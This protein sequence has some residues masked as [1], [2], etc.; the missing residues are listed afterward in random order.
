MSDNTDNFKLQTVT[1]WNEAPDGVAIQLD[2]TE[3]AW[4]YGA[5]PPRGVYDIKLFPQKDGV[6]MGRTDKNDP[7]TTY[8]MINYEG[9]VVS[10]NADYTDVPVFGNVSTRVFRGKN[11]STAAGLLVKVGVKNLPSPI[12]DKKLAQFVEQ[13]LKKEVTVK[14]ELDWRGQYKHTNDKGEDEY[15]PVFNHYEEFPVDP[16]KGG[17]KHVVSVAKRG[18]GQ[19]EVRAQL[20]VAR[21]FA[22]G[23]TL[24]SFAPTLPGGLVSGPRT[25]SLPTTV[26]SA[27]SPVVAAPTP[28]VA[29][30]QFVAPQQ[31]Q[32]TMEDLDLMLE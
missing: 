9:R 24:P 8:Y 4:E 28:V 30:P 2:L 10:E 19:A 22:K 17:K 15:I 7:N 14:A 16:D 21:F 26:V 3:D 27:P 5:P 20:R 23:D 32:Q 1:N 6:K 18:G 12:S 31:Q 11:I 13:I 29:A 25:L